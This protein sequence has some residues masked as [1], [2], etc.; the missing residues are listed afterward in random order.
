[1]KSGADTRSAL[2]DAG[3]GAIGGP[4]AV[5]AKKGAGM[6][7]KVLGLPEDIKRRQAILDVISKVHGEPRRILNAQGKFVKD[8]AR[9]PKLPGSADKPKKTD[10]LAAFGEEIFPS[11]IDA[12]PSVDEIIK[13]GRPPRNEFLSPITALEENTPPSAEEISAMM[14]DYSKGENAAARESAGLLDNAGRREYAKGLR[15]EVYKILSPKEKQSLVHGGKIPDKIKEKLSPFLNRINS[16]LADIEGRSTFSNDPIADR[17]REQGEIHMDD[18][19][20]A[21]QEAGFKKDDKL[22][23]L[24]GYTPSSRVLGRNEDLIEGAKSDL[25]AI[26]EYNR[27]DTKK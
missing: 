4:G 14:A 8:D 26:A 21:I 13:S 16:H 3:I 12:T 7:G 18:L 5:A 24:A 6:A 27:K 2:L 1:M 20:T 15:E 25:G 9:S 11:Q 17:W 23:L 10:P 22:G 19:I